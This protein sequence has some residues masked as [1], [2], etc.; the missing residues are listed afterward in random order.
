MKSLSTIPTTVFHATTTEYL[1]SFIDIDISMSRQHLDFGKGFYVT[2]NYNQAMR[3][4]YGKC[5]NYM[6]EVSKGTKEGFVRPLIMEYSINLDSLM[7]LDPYIFKIPDLKWAEFIY[8][9]RIGVNKVISDFHNWDSKFQCTYGHLADATFSTLIY[10]ARNGKISYE[11]FCK[12]IIPTRP[13]EEDQ[14]AFHTIDSI[15]CLKFRRRH[16]DYEYVYIAK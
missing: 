10:E 14:I 12:R 11:E 8:N 9:N 1:L 5:I 4:A 13:N 15:N 7:K 16:I 2:S 3:F 6:D